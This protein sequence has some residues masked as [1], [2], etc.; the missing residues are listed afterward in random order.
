MSVMIS[1]ATV[2]E[3]EAAMDVLVEWFWTVSERIGVK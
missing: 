2:V 1:S 3:G